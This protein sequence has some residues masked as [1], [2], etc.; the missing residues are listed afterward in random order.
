MR[1]INAQM[2]REGF[3]TIRG[4]VNKYYLLKKFGLA[5]ASNVSNEG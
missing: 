3:L 1:K 2:E 5:G 4:R